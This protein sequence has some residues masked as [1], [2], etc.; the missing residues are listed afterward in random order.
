MSESCVTDPTGV[1]PCNVHRSG[2]TPNVAEMSLVVHRPET[3][4]SY[5]S[6]GFSSSESSAKRETKRRKVPAEDDENIT[7]PKGLVLLLGG[8]KNIEKFRSRFKATLEI[9]NRTQIVVDST[10]MTKNNELWIK[11]KNENDLK[12]LLGFNWS[13]CFDNDESMPIVARKGKL[14]RSNESIRTTVVIKNMPRDFDDDDIMSIILENGFEVV[15]IRRFKYFRT[16][17]PTGK[18]GVNL[19]HP[20]DRLKILELGEIKCGDLGTVYPVEDFVSTPLKEKI[21]FKCNKIGHIRDQCPLNSN[22]ICSNCGDTDH[23][24]DACN[25]PPKCINCGGRH[26]SSFLDCPA[27]VAN[28]KVRQEK[29]IS[30]N[31]YPTYAAALRNTAMGSPPRNIPAPIPPRE[32]TEEVKELKL[33]VTKLED[34]ILNLNK[35]VLKLCKQLEIITKDTSVLEDVV[36]VNAETGTSVDA[37][38]SK[39]VTA[40]LPR[41]AFTVGG[42]RLKG[43]S[44]NR[45]PSGSKKRHSRKGR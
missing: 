36:V 42:K 31:R 8:I 27:R 39:E 43:R 32:T 21:C 24:S 16:L 11:C 22:D 20:E 15:S 37:C 3:P 6:L 13:C 1:G 19:A 44:R 14:R 45:R 25:V 23:Y 41:K 30:Q 29:I 2:L 18:V 12:V 33:K 5:E 34:C 17:Q 38:D 7:Q 26:R 4:M 10:S 40:L 9:K 35:L 28:R